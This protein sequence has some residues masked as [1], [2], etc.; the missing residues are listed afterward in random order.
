MIKIPHDIVDHTVHDSEAPPPVEALL[1]DLSSTN[2]EARSVARRRL[3]RYGSAVANSLISLLSSGQ[4]QTRWEAAKALGQ[5]RTGTAAEALALALADEHRDVR[6]V[7]ADGLI[8]MGEDAIVPLL[9]E[10]IDHADSVWV[11]S[12]ASH[13]L[14]EMLPQHTILKPVVV[15]LNGS[16]P[17]FEVP[18]A[19]FE[20][21]RALRYPPHR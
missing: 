7:A 16:A 19:A 8:A 12:A 10:L 15:A 4:P 11:R 1:K 2:G 3:L 5:I 18:V 17:M 20:V 21:M 13:V 14:S 9:E 6:W